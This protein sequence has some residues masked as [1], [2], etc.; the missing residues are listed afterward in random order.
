MAVHQKRFFNGCWVEFGGLILT[1]LVSFVGL[2]YGL[3][4]EDQTK[5]VV[6]LFGVLYFIYICYPTTAPPIPFPNIENELKLQ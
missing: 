4:S 6:F 3:I 5:Y 1:V 2:E